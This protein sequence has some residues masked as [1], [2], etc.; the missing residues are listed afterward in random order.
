MQCKNCGKDNL[1]EDVK[2]CPNCGMS[3]KPDERV[4]ENQISQKP[5]SYSLWPQKAEKISNKKKGWLGL[6]V[7]ILFILFLIGSCSNQ[8]HP[9]ASQPPATST[10]SSKSTPSQSENTPPKKVENWQYSEK[11][12]TVHNAKYKLARATS[13]NTLNFHFPYEGTQH[14]YLLLRKNYDGTKDAMLIINKG[15]FMTSV[16]GGKA[17]V[18]F[19][20]SSPEDFKLLSSDDHSTTVVFFKYAANFIE[21]VSKA[22][23]VYIQ[24]AFYQE[25]SPTLEFNVEGLNEL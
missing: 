21:K 18:R 25:G 20:D 7:I 19:D 6:I 9:T 3:M 23:K 17:L 15:Q 8:S 2:F 16:M 12:D 13:I 22:K 5:V 1:T 10:A 11:D 24:T 14:G 4:T